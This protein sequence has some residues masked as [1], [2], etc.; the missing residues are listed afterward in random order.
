MSD[1]ARSGR[2]TPRR[3]ILL[4]DMD[5]FFASVEQSCHPHLRG[6]AVIVCGDPSRRGVVTAASYEARPTGVHAGMP[7]AEAKRLCPHAHYVEGDPEKYV[8]MSLRLLEHYLTF[9]PDV[10]PFSVDEAFLAVG[11]VGG[12]I[13][14][15][16]AIAAG[17]QRGVLDKFELT[18]SIGVGPNKLI[19]KMASGVS[20]P[21]GL[22]AFDQ[23]AFQAH[24]WPLD[25]QQLWG[26]GQ[27]TS[28][29]LK[30]LGLATVG[31]LANADRRR[32]EA[33][34]GV[35]GPHLIDSAQGIDHTPLIPY[36][37]GVDPKSMGHEV[38]LPEDC[39]DTLALEGT[40]L[41][42]SDQVARRLRSEGF[43]ARTVTL[44]LRDHRFETRLRQRSLGRATDDHAQVYEVA[45][46]LWRE[47]WK[48]EPLRLLGVSVSGLVPADDSQQGE[49]FAVD[50]RATRLREAM[51]K[52]RDKLGEAVIVP[53][54]SLSYRRALGHVPFGAVSPRT[55]RG[56]GAKRDAATGD[57]RRGGKPEGWPDPTAR[58]PR[59]APRAESDRG[60]KHPTQR[61]GEPGSDGA[62]PD[63]R[64]R[65]DA[66][67]PRRVT[68]RDR[69]L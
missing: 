6:Q 55:G 25:V 17:I 58:A 46:A 60:P 44:K 65:G 49:L 64:R 38:T 10:E 40:L 37:E 47:L 21:F 32:L 9:T 43:R 66:T 27:Q 61:D 52:V 11:R 69:D 13:D 26:V 68:R 14:E 48:G 50:D 51:D 30:G 36:H 31:A 45:R 22:T 57:D 41:R 39:R 63:P 29:R 24:F 15:A 3:W 18:A 2:D 8:A 53:A 7:L 62:G 12:T 19:A 59:F 34:F 16:R 35:I 23:A 33:M 28:A 1:A 4:A 20:K 56:E 67:P 54:G 5:A 42:L